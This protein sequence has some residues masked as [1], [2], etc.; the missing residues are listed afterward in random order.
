MKDS[1]NG[2]PT[3]MNNNIPNPPAMI[4]QKRGPFKLVQAEIDAELH[5]QFREECA[6]QGTT[7]QAV[8]SFYIKHWLSERAGKRSK[9][10]G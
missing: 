3:E 4:R 2:D 5:T 7:M 9:R 10:V 8:V 1:K 6:K